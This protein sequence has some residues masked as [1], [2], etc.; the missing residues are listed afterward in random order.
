MKNKRLWVSIIAGILAAALLL[1]LVLSVLPQNAEAATSSELKEQLNELKS[2]RDE[3]TAQI[4]AL[5]KQQDANR[6]DMEGILQNKAALDQQIALLYANMQNVNDQIAAYRLLIADKQEELDIAQARLDELTEKNRERLRAMEE[7]GTLNYWSVIFKANSFSDLLDRVNMINEI[8]KSDRQ[9]LEQMNQAAEEVRAAKAELTTEKAA[10]EDAKAVLE[11][12][13]AVLE[14]KNQEAVQLLDDLVNA[15]EDMDAL[16]QQFEDEEEKFLQEIAKKEEEYNK[17]LAAEK[18]SSR[19]ASI[20]QSSIEASIEASI[21]ESISIEQSKHQATAGTTGGGGNDTGSTD[22]P[23]NARWLI[24]CK[25]YYVSSPFGYRWHPVT[26]KWTMHN[27]VDLPYPQGTPIYASRSGTVTIATYSSTAGNYVSLNHGDGYSSVY[28]HMT[29]YVVKVG[30]YVKAG[31][32][33]G[34]MGSTGR[35]TGPHL[36]FGISYKGTY[37]NPA[38]YM[39]L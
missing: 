17:V 11:A 23:S 10:L 29:H 3:I 5:E 33:L 12:T 14:V 32:L 19:L 9:R 8:A 25:Y 20:K 16:H 22:N 37:V 1:G 39:N 2:D 7:E 35:S 31:Q 18:E 13:Q 26:G 24:P 27:G 21:A 15:A 4:D 30:E 36:H 34:Y 28:M 38:D 6:K